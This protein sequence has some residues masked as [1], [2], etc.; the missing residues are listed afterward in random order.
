[1]RV[2][3]IDSSQGRVLVLIGMPGAGKT[4]L[5]RRLATTTGLLV[6]DTDAVIEQSMGQPLQELLDE[7]GYLKMRQLENDVICGLPRPSGNTIVATG[8]S[9][10]YG[11]A[12]MAHLQQWGL[13]LYLHISL[14]TVRRRVGNLN[15]RGFNCFPGQSLADVYAERLPLY[16]RYADTIVDCDDQSLEQT[17]AAV[18]AVMAQPTTPP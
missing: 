2:E 13:C 12:A 7:L 3:H 17:L 1:M 18:H 15:S 10:I 6:I 14:D 8:G 4:T 5:A 9:A 11:S 16:R